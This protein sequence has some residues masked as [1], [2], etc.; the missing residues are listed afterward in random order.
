MNKQRV[1]FISALAA[2]IALGLGMNRVASAQ[3][4]ASEASTAAKPQSI[5]SATIITIHGKITTVERAKKLVTLEGP[6]GHKVTLKV[7]NPYNLKAAKVGEPVV[8]RFYEVVTIR[9]KKPDESVPNASLNQGIVTARPGGVPGAVAEQQLSLLVTV[10]AID[11]PNG[12]VTIKAPDGTTETVKAR[13]PQNL[14]LIKVGDVLV[15]T[16]ARALAVSL[17]KA[18]A[19]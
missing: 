17:Q 5:T 7:E 15:V 4:N 10:D 3:S 2:T 13:D 6:D 14:K 12:T 11:E 18:S 1:V 9:K 8:V 16:V 19:S